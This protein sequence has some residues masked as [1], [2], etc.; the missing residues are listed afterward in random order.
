MPQLSKYDLQQAVVRFMDESPE[1]FLAEDV[2]LRSDLAG[3]RIFDLPLMAVAAANDPMFTEMQ[4]DEAVGALFMLPEDWLP[5]A[6]SVISFFF[7][8]TDTIIKANAMAPVDIP[9]E[10]LH[11]RIEGQAALNAAT[12]AIRDLLEN[13][14]FSCVIPS[15][16]QRF[17]SAPKR[18]GAENPEYT[19]AWSERHVAYVCGLGTFGLSRGLITARGMAG[20]FGS[21]ITTA[22]FEADTRLYSRYDEYCTMCGE[23]ALKCPVK[24]ID[25]VKGKNLAP[26]AA[27]QQETRAKHA[28]RYGCGKCSVGVPCTSAIPV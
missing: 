4:A 21:V 8:F 22:P 12:V 7:P 3:M 9:P 6:R 23:C 1:N 2:A 25:P 10:W 19:S 17:R 27:F 24:A 26:C 11:G 20:R 15:M 5:G 28:P 13:A 14:G 18:E 16:D